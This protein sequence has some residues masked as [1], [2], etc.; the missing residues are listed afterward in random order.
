MKKILML[1]SIISCLCMNVESKTILLTLSGVD[2]ISYAYEYGFDFINQQACTTSTYTP[3]YDCNNHFRFYY[4]DMI[5]AYTLSAGTG[6]GIQ[7]GKVNLDSIYTAPPDSSF[8]MS[9]QFDTIPPDSL[10]AYVGNSYIIKT[11]VDPR[12]ASIYFAKIRIVG[13]RLID[14]ATHTVEMRFIWACNVNG[15]RDIA[16]SGLDTFN[17]PTSTIHSGTTPKPVAFSTEQRVFKVVGDKFR[18]PKEL[19]AGKVNFIEVFDL[20]GKRLGAVNVKNNE[21]K[22]DK[23]GKGVLILKAN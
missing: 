15:S 10:S 19:M 17:F 6:Y 9:P 7:A 1:V 4:Y 14:S 16:T 12:D 11:G 8:K 21:V 20:R 5:S 13:F 18:I 22:I 2:T 3:P 23:I